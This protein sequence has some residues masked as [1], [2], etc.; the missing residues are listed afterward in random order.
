L[1]RASSK[2]VADEKC[3]TL[4]GRRQGPFWYARRLRPTR[5]EPVSVAFDAHWALNREESRGDVV[6]FF[7]THPLGPARPSR[8]DVKTM[9][10]WASCFGKPL[11][12]LIQSV[13]GLA[14][15]RFDNHASSG[16]ELG[17]CELF[18]R[19]IVI[20]LDDTGDE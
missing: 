20:V 19:G 16:S 11:L 9:R 13:D 6:G 18:P 7:H 3:W 1:A 4:V 15:F 2:K 17:A 10:A 14:A 5:G 12:C 8:R